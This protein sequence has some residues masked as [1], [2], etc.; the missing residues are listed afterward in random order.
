MH[1]GETFRPEYKQ[2][3]EIRALIPSGVNTMA[4]T[5]TASRYT[6]SDIIAT[7]CMENPTIIT[8]SPHKKNILY[9]VR[10]KSTMEEL[11]TIVSAIVNDLR[12]AT[13]R[14][15]IFCKRYA[16]CAQF[17]SL[18]QYY[19][20]D[21]FTEPSGSP[22]L[23]KNRL[24]DMY[25]KCTEA[26]V[27]E[28]IVKSFCKP[29]G[30]LRVVIATIAFG[31][32]LDCPDVRQIIL[33]GAPSDVEAMIQQTGR[34]GR[35]GYLSCALLLYGKGDRHLVSEPM[36]AFCSNHENCRR[37]LL[38]Q[39]FDHFKQIVKP[40]TLCNCCD[41]CASKCSCKMCTAIRLGD[42]FIYTG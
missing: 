2:L 35:D 16:E 33:W 1:R 3:G 32:G 15:I 4:L 11:V 37:E 22:D 19:L 28:T 10:Q 17:Y 26:G 39:D 38:F 20:R 23:A 21:Q 5:A 13:P 9:M 24:V 12:T 31:M 6:R 36:R 29:G 41:I 42:K 40:C 27:K 25:C 34:A 8:A 18:F 7:L 30:N 14:I